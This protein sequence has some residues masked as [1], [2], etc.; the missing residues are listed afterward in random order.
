MTR[1]SYIKHVLSLVSHANSVKCYHKSKEVHRFN[2]L[3]EFYRL[4]Q[5]D[6][7]SVRKEYGLTVGEIKDA[8]IMQGRKAKAALADKRSL[9]ETMRD[10]RVYNDRNK[11]YMGKRPTLE[12]K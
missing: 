5:S 7:E 6:S 12:D 2:Q 11:L 3:L 9:G 8:L 1:A 4:A 10:R